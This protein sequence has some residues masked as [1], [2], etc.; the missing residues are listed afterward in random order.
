MIYKLIFTPQVDDYG[1]LHV[2]RIKGDCCNDE[3][4]C[5]HHSVPQRWWN[6]KLWYPPYTTRFT[7]RF[8]TSL[9]YA[10]RRTSTEVVPFLYGQQVLS[11]PSPDLTLEWMDT[12][13]QENKRHIRHVV[14]SRSNDLL[15]GME[16]TMA[17]AWAEVL[18]LLPRIQSMTVLQPELRR[19]ASRHTDG[20]ASHRREVEAAISALQRLTFLRLDA[21]GCSLRFLTNKPNLETLILKPS[22]FGTEDWDDAFAHLPRLKNL[23]LD[24]TEVPEDNLALFPAHFLGHTAHLRSFGWKGALL[25]KPSPRTSSSATAPRCKSSISSTRPLPPATL[26][27]PLQ[28]PQSTNLPSPSYST[29][30]PSRPCASSTTTTPSSC[31]TYFAASSN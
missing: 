31:S 15:V 26:T 22:G 24:M 1:C 6:R 12:I 29:S 23:F 11:L 2:V 3:R 14:M 4:T 18:E 8:G 16:D 30:P 13:G 28:R 25:P 21:H 10:C 20:E 19:R 17:G 7:A 27:A 5:K 9:L